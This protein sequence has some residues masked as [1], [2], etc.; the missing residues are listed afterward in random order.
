MYNPTAHPHATAPPRVSRCAHY[1]TA[2][3]HV[4]LTWGKCAA[5]T[6]QGFQQQPY[7]QPA[8]VSPNPTTGRKRKTPPDATSHAPL[9]PPQHYP[10]MALNQQPYQ[11][12][13][14]QPL[15]QAPA[16][17]SNDDDA[18][19]SSSGGR[20]LSTSKRAEQNR[21]AQRAFRERRDQC[22]SIGRW[23][24]VCTRALTRKRQTRQVAREPRPARRR[25]ARVRRGGQPPLGGVPQSR[26]PT[27]RGKRSAQGSARCGLCRPGR[28][29]PS[30]SHVRRLA[31]TSRP[32]GSEG[33][34]LGRCCTTRFK[35]RHPGAR[36][37]AL[38]V[39]R[40]GWKCRTLGR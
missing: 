35:R 18:A 34:A 12:L 36:S 23:P 28:D 24:S 9:P 20:A 29:T 31:Y 2:P 14:S 19:G 8:S 32:P 21:K 4:Q 38:C 7:P 11:Q 26:R 39:Y 33:P 10:P 40:P 37:R 17:P 16:A 25:R 6:P 27:A 1:T 15:Q 3:F 30:K 13:V 22:V 5:P